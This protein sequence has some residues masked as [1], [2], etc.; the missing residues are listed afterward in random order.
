[1]TITVA[2]ELHIMEIKEKVKANVH[3]KRFIE[4]QKKKRFKKK[5]S[6]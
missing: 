3:D 6:Q 4:I 2:F 1:M 5:N